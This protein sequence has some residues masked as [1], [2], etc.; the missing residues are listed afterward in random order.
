MDG[1][2]VAMMAGAAMAATVAAAEGS[3]ASIITHIKDGEQC[4]GLQLGMEVTGIDEDGDGR[5]QR[6]CLVDEVEVAAATMLLSSRN[7]VISLHERGS[8]SEAS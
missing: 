1:A 6:W 3:M 4:R 2:A 5:C 8:W 7:S